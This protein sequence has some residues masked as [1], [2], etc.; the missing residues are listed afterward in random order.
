MTNSNSKKH[1]L[2]NRDFFILWQG[3]AISKIGTY[4][5]DI[6]LI[7]W[8]QE[9]A[10][11]AGFIAIILIASNIPEILLSPFGGTLA[12]TFSRRKILIYSDLIGG[13][14]VTG[15]SLIL[16]FNIFPDS[17]NYMLLFFVSLG[18]G[19]CTAT[20][21]PT[22]SSYIPDLVE[23]DRLHKANSLFESTGRITAIAGQGIGGVLFSILGGPIMFLINGISYIFSGISES[24]LKA[25]KNQ[26]KLNKDWKQNLG[27]FKND[28]KE[29]YFYCWKNKNLRLFLIII[30]IYHFF[31]APLPILLPFL[32]SDTLKLDHDWLGYLL[33]V[34]AAG[35]LIGF[36]IAGIIKIADFQIIKFVSFLMLVSSLAYIALG[37]FDSVYIALLCLLIIGTI[38]GIIVI[39][40]ITYMQKNTAANMRGRLFGFL[41]TITNSTTPIGLAVYG[42]L[43]DYLRGT[44]VNP[45][46]A[47]QIMFGSTGVLILFTMIIIL[48]K[49]RGKFYRLA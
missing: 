36:T 11:S 33:A 42:V 9:K 39:T 4:L 22:V 34:F 10:N 24:F 29:G 12:D 6:A 14:L 2:F 20:F 1:N 43:I 45:G 27:S 47:I 26:K 48:L 37:F 35:T 41:N 31:V 38:I 44:F 8:L 40:L 23:K 3:N 16:L 32:I 15:I 46:F 13:L 49:T 30:A 18:L 5:F 19:I 28:F 17:L 21:N 7:L 25:D